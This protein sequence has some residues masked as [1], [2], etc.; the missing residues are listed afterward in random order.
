MPEMPNVGMSMTRLYVPECAKAGEELWL[1]G[2]RAHYLSR[3][4]R[5]RSGDSLVVFDGTGGEYETTVGAISRQRVQ[6]LP[7]EFSPRDIESPLAIRLIQGISRGDRMDIVVQ[8]ATELGVWRISP[9]FTE[10]SIVRLDP[11]RQEKKIYHWQ[12]I[13]QSACEQCGR[14]VVPQIDSPQPLSALLEAPPVGTCIALVPGGASGLADLPRVEA[15]LTLLIGPEGGLSEM[16][17]AR[18]IEQGFRTLSLGPRILRTE[19]AALAA[20][21]V[22]QVRFGDLSG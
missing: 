5:I 13:A 4:L 16:E 11:D 10:F 3:V 9:V 2:E 21:T 1:E 18:A 15:P 6:L 20:L 8:K 17:C 19:T 22:L 7:G 12:R 14:N